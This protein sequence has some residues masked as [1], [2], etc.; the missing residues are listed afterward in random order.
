M[1]LFGPELGKRR[2]AKNLLEQCEKLNRHRWLKRSGE[3]EE[4]MIVERASCGG[5]GK[6][7]EPN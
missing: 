4:V 5:T 1:N 6:E 3:R 2:G 7:E